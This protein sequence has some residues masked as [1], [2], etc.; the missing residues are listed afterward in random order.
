MRHFLAITFIALC[1]NF[2]FAQY[3]AQTVEE[4]LAQLEAEMDSMSIFF[5]LDSVLSTPSSYKYSELDLRTSFNSNITS[6]GRNYNFNQ[7]NISPGVSYYHKSGVF[8]DYAGFWNSGVNPKYNLSVFSAGYMG[9]LGKQ[10]AFSSSYER[11]WYHGESSNNL[12]NTFSNT[13]IFSKKY[14]YASLDYSMLFGEGLAHRLVGTMTGSFNLGKWWKFKSIKILPTASAIFGNAEITILYDGS[15]LE[16]LR[17]NDYVRDNLFTRDF[18]EYAN[19]VMSDE[20]KALR[21][22]IIENYSRRDPERQRRLTLLYLSNPDIYNY[23]IDLLNVSEE[24]YGIMN[25]NFSLPIIFS[26]TKLSLMLS[27]TYSIPVSLPGENFT[28]DPIGFFGASA[29]YRI[30]FKNK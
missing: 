1:Y 9:S 20:E 13:L 19:T 12:N 28:M 17:S 22:Q 30:P 29:I 14:F 16:D 5:L 23:I 26:S 10:W 27:Y 6:A 11:W 3:D 8:L 24:K 18:V 21:R 25:Y 15:L 2:T 7:Q 4:Q